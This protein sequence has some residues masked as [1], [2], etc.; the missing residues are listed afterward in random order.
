MAEANTVLEIQDLCVKVKDKELLHDLNL[1]IPF[2]EVHA[3]LGQN[4]SGKTSLMMAIMGFSGYE[5]THGHI[6]FAG[7][8]ITDMDLTQ[9]RDSECV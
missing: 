9:R 1:T 5:V 7:K 4:G 3:L 2:G 6:F 8:E